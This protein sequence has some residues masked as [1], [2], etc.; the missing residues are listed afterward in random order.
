[1]QTLK[2]IREETYTRLG[3]STVHGVGVFAVRD[4]PRHTN[5]FPS[6]G[7]GRERLVGIRASDLVREPAHI[8]RAIR[9]FFPADG[10]GVHWVSAWGL[11]NLNVS[12][13]LNHSDTPN[14]ET[15][16]SDGPYVGFRTL[17]DVKAGEELC[18]SYMAASR[19]AS[20][21]AS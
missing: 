19:I 7:R 1:M 16:G 5:P 15:H 4:I 2:Q 12:F 6:R 9:D 21:M 8:Q 10:E 14:V 17:R 3:V 11:N 13:Y 20:T 18:Y